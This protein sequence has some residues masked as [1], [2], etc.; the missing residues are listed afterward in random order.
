MAVRYKYRKVPGGVVYLYLRYNFTQKYLVDLKEI[1]GLVGFWET[2]HL[3][4][5]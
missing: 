1:V 3:P 2:V 4:L 5:P